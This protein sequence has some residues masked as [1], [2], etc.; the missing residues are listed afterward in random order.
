MENNNR[1]AD[2]VSLCVTRLVPGL[3]AILLGAGVVVATGPDADPFRAALLTAEHGPVATTDASLDV[4]LDFLQELGAEFDGE[5]SGP[6]LL[7]CA[8][9]TCTTEHRTIC[10][11]C[12]RTHSGECPDTSSGCSERI[13]E[14]MKSSIVCWH[15]FLERLHGV[16]ESFAEAADDRWL[17]HRESRC[18]CREW[19]ECH[20]VN[21]RLGSM[22]LEGC[23]PP[24]Y[25][26]YCFIETV[27]HAVWFPAPLS[28]NGPI[29]PGGSVEQGA[30]IDGPDFRPMTALSLSIDPPAGALPQ[31]RAVEHFSLAGT[32]AHLPGT[33]RLWCGSSYYWDASLLNHQPLYFEDVNLERHGFSYGLLQP[34]VSGVKFFGTIPSLPYRMT[35]EPPQLTYF[36]LGEQRPGS[37]ANYVHEVPPVD[38]QAAGAQALTIVGLV[39]IIP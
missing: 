9:E 29:E 30:L 34:L 24:G 39:F 33:Q 31:D 1:C 10:R 23:M 3:A 19:A 32:H 17:G 14:A 15:A 7:P 38:A 25:D 18:G 28:A 20:F 8:F 26:L 22:Y 11:R 35:A 27:P 21:W 4:E 2:F 12:Q 16:E 5:W 36:S 6:E 13:S 37:H